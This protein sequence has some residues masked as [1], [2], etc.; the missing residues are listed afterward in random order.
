MAISTPVSMATASVGN[1]SLMT[2]NPGFAGAPAGSM[3]VVIVEATRDDT[4]TVTD[5]KGNTYQL[6]ISGKPD[7]AAGCTAFIFYALDV[8]AL[9]PVGGG[10]SIFVQ[11]AGVAVDS[12]ATKFHVE[13]VK[14]TAALDLAVSAFGN[15]ASPS[16]ASGTP[17]EAGELFIAVA[18]RRSAANP[19]VFTPDSEFSTPP[20]SAARNSNIRINGGYLI[21]AGLNAHT[22]DP[23]ITSRPW[24]AL[25]ASFKAEP[26]DDV[27]ATLSVTLDG[28]TVSSTAA[29]S[30]LAE[31][32][33]AL[34]GATL[35][36]SANPLVSAAVNKALDA[37]SAAIAAVATVQGA[38]N[39]TL[40]GASLAAEAEPVVSAALGK[41][42]DG[43][44]ATI[45]AAARVSAQA[46]VTLDS[47]TL[48]AGA[49][50]PVAA[51]LLKTLDDAAA[52]AFAA[53][54]V[55]ANAGVTLA[56]VSSAITSVV[57][58]K[59]A[60]A[61][62]LDDASLSAAAIRIPETETDPSRV[63]H[64][65]AES[66]SAIVASETRLAA[67]SAEQR[68]ATVLAEARLA[69][70]AAETRSVAVPAGDRQAA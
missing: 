44:Q 30:V 9:A 5:T 49:N 33:K 23:T 57:E 36:A 38:L 21:E 10:D 47:A 1:N 40:D 14:K 28:A 60:L 52:S 32:A 48:A 22:F 55:S 12:C 64:L 11:F 39:K 2:L 68:L 59:A 13:G 31:V 35:V 69:T 15:S 65:A 25:I 37:V 43:V 7:N 45:A 4:P 58:I 17:A 54:R 20:G 19:D 29:V 56:G 61:A 46:S 18:C 70:V 53:A 42:L 26:S 66:R 67:A 41:E 6:A 34:D 3:V 24:T 50:A 16:V 27:E 63:I 62:T 51:A 8:V